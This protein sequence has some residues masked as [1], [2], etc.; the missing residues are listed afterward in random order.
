MQELS[1]TRPLPED[2]LLGTATA[3]FQIEG[4]VDEG[5]RG[6]SIWDTFTRVPGAILRGENADVAC[7]HYHRYPE[8]V[9][10][11]KEMGLDS[12]RFSIAWPR[13]FP[14]GKTFNAGGADFYSRLVDELLAAEILPWPTLYHWDLPQA[15]QDEGGWLV[16]DTAARFTDYAVK[17]QEVL[18]D[19]LEA[20]TTLNEPWCSSFLSHTAGIHAPGQMSL[21][22]GLLSSHHLL[23]GHGEA[24]EA[25]REAGSDLDLG[26][27]LNLTVAE[28]ANPDS[29][30]DQDAAR[31]IDGQFNRWFLDPIFR[32][33][34]P[35]D[36]VSD[37]EKVD[38]V[39]VAE[40]RQAIH[41]GDLQTIATPLDFLGINYYHCEYVSGTKPKN[42]SERTEADTA[43]QTASP[44]PAD[45][46]IYWVERGK[47]RTA[48]NWEVDAP[49]LT[50]LLR[51]V[52]EQY[53]EPAGVP[54]YVTENG[55]AF[56][57]TGQTVAGE[58]RIAD[59]ERS[60]YLVDHIAATLD[61]RE[62]G[63]DVRGYYW[64]SLLDNFEWAWGY[65]P[66]FGLFTVDDRTRDRHWKDSART[67]QQILQD[68][69]L[70]A[71]KR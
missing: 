24:L 47:P 14:D 17:V 45:E 58:M 31:R 42:E 56:E 48:M 71:V 55:A 23:L 70:P 27:T 25:L 9:G 16:R 46:N 44:F 39:A 38:P 1:A 29:P 40:W 7:D 33:E 60:Q 34:Y 28:P 52:W 57:D 22:A 62:A 30:A 10:L 63:V 69:A 13:L 50:E 51:N 68:R 59:E 6:P 21:R 19:R 26:I 37:F 35:E 53:A 2:F 65:Q 49:G 54:L 43:R 4:G 64:W 67:Y 8:D 11:M 3:A 32:G 18:G 12:Y 41:P 5:G 61:A 20:L 66:R 36:I 15:L